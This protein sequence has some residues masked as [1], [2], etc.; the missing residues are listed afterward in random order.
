MTVNLWTKHFM[1]ISVANLLLF[2]SLYM[3]LPVLPMELAEQIG[4]KSEQTGL[5]FLFFT[6]GMLFVGPF[7][8]YLIDVYKRKYICLFS[9]LLVTGATAGYLYVGALRELFLLAAF[10]GAMFG[11]ATTAGI[12]LAIDITHSG[13]RSIGNLSFAWM[14]RLGMVI[15]IALGIWLYQM[16]SFTYLIA[17]SV[18]AGLL[19]VLL[20]SMVYVPFRAPIVTCLCSCDRFLLLRGWVPALNLVMISFVL[21]LLTAIPHLFTSFTLNESTFALPFFAVTVVGFIV[22]FCCSRI[23]LVQDKLF[24][25]VVLG[26]FLF[27]SA[28]FM[29]SYGTFTVVAFLVLG[30]GLGLV[31]PEFLTMFVKLSKHCQRGTANTTHLLCCEI[32]IALGVALAYVYDDMGQ[33]LFFARISALVALVFFAVFTYPY[34]IK[35]KVR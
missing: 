23:R 22:S 6:L 27:V 25:T 8:A 5:M 33:I 15:G 2:I 31:T 16:A 28:L 24:H 26:L 20:T 18:G 35:K 7:H 17:I 1:R 14:A 9:T 34:Y 29:I 3:L 32:G 11:L 4:L 30:I 13:S 19:S 10:Q 12:T 21:G